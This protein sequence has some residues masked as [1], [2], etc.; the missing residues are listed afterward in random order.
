VTLDL[1][2]RH[3]GR[4]AVVTGSGRGLGLEIARRL[5]NEGANVVVTDVVAANVTEARARLGDADGRTIG[6]VADLATEDGAQ[7]LI[8]AAIAR[9]GRVDILIN[10]A[11]GGHIRPFM[12]H[13]AQTLRE[14]LDRNLWTCLWCCRVALPHMVQRDYGRIVNVGAD[15]VR[16]GLDSHAGYNA[17]KGGVHGLTTGLAREFAKQDITINTV[18]P[19]GILTPEIRQML[20]PQSEVYAKHA[21]TNINTLVGMVPKGRFAEM[22]EVASFVSYVAAEEARFITGQVLSVN[23][24]STML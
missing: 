11:G 2:Q 4:V 14:T 21:I 6:H 3:A 18:A 19:G 24:G 1:H 22:E 20:D 10:N 12:I 9:W 15:S 8:G 17:A 13:K 16:N 7:G 5:L 23:G